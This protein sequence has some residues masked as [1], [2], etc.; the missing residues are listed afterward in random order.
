MPSID[1]SNVTKRYGT[2]TALD[3]LS[4]SVERGEIYG[5]LGPNGAG[6]STTI[7]LLLDFI[8]PT[9]GEV[10]VFDLDAQADSLEIR[11][12]TGILPEGAELYERLT[13]RQHVEFAIESK[14]ADDDPDEL[15]ERV[16]LSPDAAAKKAGGYSKGMAQRLTFAT[17]LVGEPDLLILDE[18]STGLDP[19]GARR[20][21]EIIREE[22]ERGA[23]VF[24]SSHVLG[25]VEAV[26]DRV[27]ILRDGDLITEDTVEGLRDSMPDQTRLRVTL[28]RIP[29]DSDAALAA[30]EAIDGVSSVTPEGR[31]LVVA[32]ED[33][34][35]TEVLH[36][37]EEYGVTVE[38]FETDESSLED[39][40][41]AYTTGAD[42]GREVVR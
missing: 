19:N 29:D 7:N 12:R 13:G 42:G 18:P 1:I 28:D 20:M 32:C 36:V 21:R 10:R 39:L 11:Q 6:K 41:V 22:N 23:T 9:T 40:F 5:F 2:E 34:A 37:V 38:D 8:R 33:R 4:L 25:Q 30:V 27:G 31:S 24:F 17:A 26:C 35:K 3:G 15:I 14:G 16:G